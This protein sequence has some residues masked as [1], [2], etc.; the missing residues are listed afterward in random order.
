[1]LGLNGLGEYQGVIAATTTGVDNGNTGVAFTLPGGISVY[2]ETD[3]DVY[4]SLQSK[5][6]AT[7]P[8][9]AQSQKLSAGSGLYF[10]LKEDKAFICARTA[11]GT[12]SV[13][14]FKTS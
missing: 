9:T 3:N 12:A 2:V 8:T 6:G 5:S 4:L 7:P 1:M 14:V 11:T 13:K 10:T